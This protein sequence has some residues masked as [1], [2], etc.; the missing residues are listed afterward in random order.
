MPSHTPASALI[1]LYFIGGAPWQWDAWKERTAIRHGLFPRD[2]DDL[3][4]GL[5]RQDAIDI[6]SYFKAYQEQKS[7]DDKI[8][9]ATKTRG[10]PAYPGR[11]TWNTFVSK[12]WPRWRIHTVIVDELKEWDIHP[13]DIVLRENLKSGW[14]SSDNFVPII[15]DT[16]GLRLFGEDGSAQGTIMT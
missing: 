15:L 3:P 10:A 5:S 9:F 14:P 12:N 8:T 2:D 7:E 11:K 13:Y 6:E 1:K 16:L 4:P